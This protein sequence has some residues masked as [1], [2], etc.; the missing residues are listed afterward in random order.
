MKRLIATALFVLPAWSATA[1]PIPIEMEC[2]IVAEYDLK[3]DG[4]MK[5]SEHPSKGERF[6]VSRRTGVIM[7]KRFS[8]DREKITV[9]D[10]GST[11]QS[12]KMISTNTSGYVHATYLEINVFQKSSKKEFIIWLYNRAVTGLCQ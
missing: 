10:S 12:F 3:P 7:G 2:T 9:L 8:N 6:M 5:A 4:T 11:E 1:Q